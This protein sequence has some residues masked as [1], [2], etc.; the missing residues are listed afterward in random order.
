MEKLTQAKIIRA[1]R[2]FFNANVWRTIS[3]VEKKKEKGDKEKIT[4][5]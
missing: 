1:L 4:E 2:E 5:H 3:K